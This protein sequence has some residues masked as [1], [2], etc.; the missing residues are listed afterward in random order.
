M[1]VRTL[2]AV[3]LTAMA[4]TAA[5][6]QV[7]C[8]GPQSNAQFQR[9]L[10]RPDPRVTQLMTGT[11]YSETRSP[12]TGQVSY[13]YQSFERNGLWGYRNRVCGGP[14]CSNYEGT[15]LYA[16]I[17]QGDGSINLLIA[18]SDQRVTNGCTASVVRLVAPGVLRDANG[19]ISRKVR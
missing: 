3:A 6:A 10:A 12:A 4:A 17:V 13:S 19:G 11:W 5:P 2:A 15:G 18:F 9:L 8:G 14:L 16:G 1:V 7:R